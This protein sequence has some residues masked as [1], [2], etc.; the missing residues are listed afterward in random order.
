MEATTHPA[1]AGASTE[2]ADRPLS[3][4]AS[5]ILTAANNGGTV[6]S[7]RSAVNEVAKAR[8]PEKVPPEMQA[9]ALEWFLADDEGEFE[10]P[11]K[12]NVGGPVDEDGQPLKADTNPPK[13]IEWT[14]RPL[15]LDTIRRIRRQSQRSDNRRQRRAGQGEFDDTLFNLGVVVEATVYPDLRAAAQR[16]DMADPRK[17]LE[18]RFQRKSGLV[19]QI[20]GEVLDLSGYNEDDVQEATSPVQAAGN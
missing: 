6:D 19:G 1:P 4:P 12:L 3:G 2:S 10:K 20:V 7:R 17:A 14:I 16:K 9:D 5:D 13:W 18:L 8:Q 11:L 15:D